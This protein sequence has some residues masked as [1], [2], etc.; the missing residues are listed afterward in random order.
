MVVQDPSWTKELSL[1]TV[2][3]VDFKIS[4]RINDVL[5]FS[6]PPSGHFSAWGEQ[7]QDTLLTVAPGRGMGGRVGQGWGGAG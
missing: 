3:P 7:H 1:P 6:L 2:I 4:G 5:Q